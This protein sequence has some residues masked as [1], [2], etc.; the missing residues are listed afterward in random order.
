[1]WQK[2]KDW[3]AREWAA[4]K[5]SGTML[6]AWLGTLSGVI[7]AAAKDFF[8]DQTVSDAVKGALDPKYVPYYII[9]AFVLLRFVRK[10]NSDL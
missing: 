2:F 9:G 1:M 5:K 4:V 10:A 6:F 3:A 7:L 8:N